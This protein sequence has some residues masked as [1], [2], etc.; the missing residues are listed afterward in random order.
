MISRNSRRAPNPPLSR[1]SGWWLWGRKMRDRRID[2]VGPVDEV[3]IEGIPKCGTWQFRTRSGCQYPA[4]KG[5]RD[6]ERSGKSKNPKNPGKPGTITSD[7]RRHFT[8]F[9]LYFSLPYEETNHLYGFFSP[10]FYFCRIQEEFPH[11]SFFAVGWI[12]ACFQLQSES[13]L[14][15]LH[16]YVISRHI[17][18]LPLPNP[19]FFGNRFRF[20]LPVF[21]NHFPKS[22]IST[23]K[24]PFSRL[25]VHRCTTKYP[26]A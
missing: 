11:V 4:S 15:F 2:G 8:F 14:K 12:L 13:F 3:K 7:Q 5:S 24:A 19:L 21:L 26:T 16:N 1:N 23:V 17:Y 6:Q 10:S 22:W 9:F 25:S 18:H 20:S